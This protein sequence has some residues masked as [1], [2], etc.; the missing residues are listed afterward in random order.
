MIGKSFLLLCV[1]LSSCTRLNLVEQLEPDDKR[2][3]IVDTDIKKRAFYQLDGCYYVPLTVYMGKEEVPLFSKH[4]LR[5]RNISYTPDLSTGQVWLF[6]LSE[7]EVAECMENIKGK[8]PTVALK[9]AGDAAAPGIVSA[10]D[11]DFKRAEVF[12]TK[13]NFSW[14]APESACPSQLRE[15]YYSPQSIPAE[16]GSYSWGYYV[17]FGPVWCTDALGN[18]AIGAVEGVAMAPFVICFGGVYLLLKATS[19]HGL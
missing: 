15:R 8:K 16:Q 12:Y 13:R 3:P 2:V 17:A 18:V 14:Y 4:S 19:V 9:Q 6:P 11:F 10:K 7:D 1:G 5:G